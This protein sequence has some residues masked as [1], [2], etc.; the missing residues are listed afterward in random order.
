MSPFVLLVTLQIQEV[1]GPSTTTVASPPPPN[2][3]PNPLRPSTSSRQST[4]ESANSLRLPR[5]PPPQGFVP[6]FVNKDILLEQEQDR[7]RLG[8]GKSTNTATTASAARRARSAST[9]TRLG[10][11]ARDDAIRASFSDGDSQ[12]SVTTAEEADVDGEMEDGPPSLP[13]APTTET[14]NRAQTQTDI[15]SSDGGIGSDTE[16]VVMT[17]RLNRYQNQ[18]YIIR[19]KTSFPTN[20]IPDPVRPTATPRHVTSSRLSHHPS[21]G[22][23]ASHYAADFAPISAEERAVLLEQLKQ[24]ATTPS[25]SGQQRHQ[26][27]IGERLKRALQPSSSGQGS[28]SSGG[29]VAGVPFG[30]GSS[31]FAASFSAAP[32]PPRPS[33]AGTDAASSNLATYQPPWML[34]APGFLKEESERKFKSLKSSLENA[35]LI[36]SGE[37]KARVSSSIQ[38]RRRRSGS[39]A[40]D[41]EMEDG[42]DNTTV[43]QRSKDSKESKKSTS[44]SKRSHSR[45]ASASGKGGMFGASGSA[46][47]KEKNSV[48][49]LRAMSRRTR[50]S[51]RSKSVSLARGLSTSSGSEGENRKPQTLSAGAKGKGRERE[52]PAPPAPSSTSPH[53]QPNSI[54][55]SV[56]M[57]TMCMAIPLWDFRGEE[58]QR[59]RS[60]PKGTRSRSASKSAAHPHAAVERSWLLV[61]Y[62]PFE[63]D[64]T[65][66]MHQR[67]K[68][69][70]SS[71]P[72]TPS[73]PSFAPLPPFAPPPG[74]AGSSAADPKLRTRSGSFGLTAASPLGS[75]FFP[76]SKSGLK[77]KNRRPVGTMVISPPL[78]V[79]PATPALMA[80]FGGG[81]LHIP[82]QQLRSVPL[83]QSASSAPG[84]TGIRSF[85]IVGRILTA[86]QLRHSGLRYPGADSAHKDNKS[87]M[88]S[89]DPEDIFTAVIAICHD[90]HAGRIEF[91]PE[92]LDA[93]GFCGEAGAPE[94][95]T[96]ATTPW[97]F[98]RECGPL[99]TVGREVVEL[100]WAGGVA[101][102]E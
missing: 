64:P 10:P 55:D 72:A 76:P 47:P 3:N 5:H 65:V 62:V 52:T 31:T 43:G 79:A 57:D 24:H 80:A 85:R 71:S 21:A 67:R 11:N 66:Q 87:T 60:G 48:G 91:V 69:G 37:D 54:L 95:V 22:A 23:L 4:A 34:M 89:S 41:V 29:S 25:S 15:S 6:A 2:P 30:A 94:R 27:G 101:L 92:G 97:T 81:P 28:G 14:R 39:P 50:G 59:L 68:G 12:V 45:M 36:L 33:S 99:S 40:D 7:E 38:R 51:G 46:P 19:P 8:R 73:A 78:A 1:P 56:A 75:L 16:V 32:L 77:K 83:P 53:Y 70:M 49:D 90:T 74:F 102:I 13:L 17:R 26:L 35:G 20:P 86:E 58:D 42:D 9:K 18:D 84:P 63:D 96:G 100:C 61:T 82:A 88:P 44:S 98:E 93:L